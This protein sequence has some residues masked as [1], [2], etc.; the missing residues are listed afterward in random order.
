MLFTVNHADPTSDASCTSPMPR[1]HR[2]RRASGHDTPIC[3]PLGEN[4]ITQQLSIHS[5]AG[6]LSMIT[7][8]WLKTADNVRGTLISKK[9]EKLPFFLDFHACQSS[10]TSQQSFFLIFYSYFYTPT[11]PMKRE[12]DALHQRVVPDRPI[13]GRPIKSLCCSPVLH[14]IPLEP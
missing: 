10:E 7:L 8:N 2:S 12:L 13:K 9:D 14:C 11:Q 3:Y 5:Q 1:A 6:A 4:S